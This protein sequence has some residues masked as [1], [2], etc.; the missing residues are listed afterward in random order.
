MSYSRITAFRLKR[1][2]QCTYYLFSALFSIFMS[3][4]MIMMQISFI[5][6][7]FK[8]FDCEINSLTIYI[9]RVITGIGNSSALI[10]PSIRQLNIFYF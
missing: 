6:Q 8:L 9:E 3:S 7:L 1:E 5:D 2:V 4:S 10:C